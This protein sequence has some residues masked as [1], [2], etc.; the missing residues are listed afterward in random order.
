M[1]PG[2]GAHSFMKIMVAIKD[3]LCHT[4]FATLCLGVVFLYPDRLFSTFETIILLLLQNAAGAVPFGIYD[5]SIGALLSD[6]TS[7]VDSQP[8]FCAGSMNQKFGMKDLSETSFIIGGH[9]R[10]YGQD[11]ALG[12]KFCIHP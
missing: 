5:N 9:F 11:S 2:P 3:L 7:L 12:L 4:S 8:L 6:P 10:K 1:R